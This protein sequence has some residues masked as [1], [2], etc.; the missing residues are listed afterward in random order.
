[1]YHRDISIGNIFSGISRI[2][3][4]EREGPPWVGDV[5]CMYADEFASISGNSGQALSVCGSSWVT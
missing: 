2:L 4:D 3:G 5:D 1:M